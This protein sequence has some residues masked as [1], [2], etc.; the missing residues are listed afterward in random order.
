MGWG[1]GNLSVSMATTA[2]QE[3]CV[4]MWPVPGSLLSIKQTLFQLLLAFCLPNQ[5]LTER[6]FHVTSTV[7]EAC[8]GPSTT[9]RGAV[10][11]QDSRRG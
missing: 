2:G 5:T 7:M 6:Q 8:T 10:R 3:G 11:P 9:E 4:G 1:G